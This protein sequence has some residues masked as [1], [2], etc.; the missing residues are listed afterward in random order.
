M[1]IAIVMVVY[2]EAIVNTPV[3]RCFTALDHDCFR[4]YVSDNSTDQAIL[5]QNVEVAGIRYKANGGN[6]GLSKAYNSWI[7]ESLN[8]VD[9]YL[10]FDQDTPVSKG[11]FDTVLHDLQQNPDVLVLVPSV[12]AG[13][14]KMSPLVFD[15][16]KIAVDGD[17]EHAEAIMFINSGSVIRSDV[18]RQV[19]F[20]NEAMFL[21]C[22]DYDFSLKCARHAIPIKRLNTTLQQNFSGVESSGLSRDLKRFKIYIKDFRILQENPEVSEK[23][24]RLLWKRALKLAVKYKSFAPLMAIRRNQE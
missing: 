6:I 4:L 13:D 22:V 2:N 10:I 8:D 3:Y 20:Y 12:T 1:T 19:G 9:T 16:V 24:G 15:P 11:Y 23:S 5:D 18:Y 14:L 21:D 7:S 17:A